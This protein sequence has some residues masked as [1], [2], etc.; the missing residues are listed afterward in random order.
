MNCLWGFRITRRLSK[1]FLCK[2]SMESIS[3]PLLEMC[4]LVFSE[5]KKW[6]LAAWRIPVATPSWLQI[7]PIPCSE[8]NFTR[9]EPHRGLTP[10][11]ERW[12]MGGLTVV[13][14]RRNVSF[15]F[16]WFICVPINH[17]LFMFKPNLTLAKGLSIHYNWWPEFLNDCRCLGAYSMLNDHRQSSISPIKN[18]ISKNPEQLPKSE[19]LSSSFLH[20]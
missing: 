9:V 10:K 5:R 4:A 18:K 16:V 12:K 1:S 6:K 7:G 14:I 8:Y 11:G 2:D 13:K 19:S 20:V 15:V 17:D 3:V